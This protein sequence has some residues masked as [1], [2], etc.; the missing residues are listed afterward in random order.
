MIIPVLSLGL[1]VVRVGLFGWL[2]LGA[3]I[4]LGSKTIWW[5]RER[6]RGKFS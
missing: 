4:I 3:F 2:V 1:G 5:A 6:S